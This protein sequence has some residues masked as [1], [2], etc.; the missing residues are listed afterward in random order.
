MAAELATKL[1]KAERRARAA[2]Q[3]LARVREQVRAVVGELDDRAARFAVGAGRS[4]DRR[5][6]EWFSRGLTMAAEL[7]RA[8]VKAVR[9]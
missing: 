6:L 5:R 8:D 2:E 9:S 1:E 3:K 4:R 7:L